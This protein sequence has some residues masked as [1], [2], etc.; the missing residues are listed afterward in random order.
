M[1]AYTTIDDPEAFFQVVTYTGDGSTQA[2]TLPGDTDMQPDFVWIKNRDAT[3]EQVAFD[4]VSGVQE[5]Y[6][7]AA[8]VIGDVTNSDTLTAFGSD[9][10]TVGADVIV[11]TNTEK[12]VAYCWKAGT[13][14][15]INATGANITP[16]AYSFNQT[17]GF[18]I[19]NY[20]GTGT[21]GDTVAH[22]LAAVPHFWF[23][24]LR[25]LSSSGRAYH[26]GSDPTAPEDKLYNIT[27]DEAAQDDT[28][29][30]WNDTAPTSVL[31]SLGNAGEVNRSNG[32]NTYRFYGWTSIQGFS[33]FGSYEGNGNA[34]GTFVY[35]GFR[36]AFII[37]KSVDSGS[38]WH[39]FDHRREGYN[40]DNDALD[41]TTT[42]AESTTDMIDILSNGFKCRISGDPNVAETY[43]F[44]AW[45][46]AP[47]VNS[48]GVPCCAR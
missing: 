30:G 37:C 35:T 48:E 19:L 11:N 31:F 15:G 33:K 40:V 29:A 47:F 4:V 41:W 36:P 28:N 46:I 16:S 17:S 26:V 23:I 8:D 27:Y 6:T 44:M 42:A 24:K 34:N 9:G 2:V 13:A 38:P 3:D 18:S 12:Y 21:G 32:G 25:E 22:G 5:Q 7:M 1:A 10:F 14:S 45:A 20:T 39:M 43:I